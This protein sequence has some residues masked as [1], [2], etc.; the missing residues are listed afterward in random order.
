M[1]TLIVCRSRS[2]GNTGKVARAMARVLGAEVVEPWAIEPHRVA[3]YDLVGFGS[4]IYA[5]SF[6]HELRRFVASI[7]AAQ[8]ASAFVFATAGFGRVI[9]RPFRERLST[10]VEAAGYRLIGSFCC[11][12]FDTW[13]PLRLVGGLNKGRPNEADLE[14]ARKFAQNLSDRSR[15]GNRERSTIMHANVGD[16]IVVDAPHTGDVQR[17]GEIV[18]VLDAGG[19]VHYR[20]RW[21]D[22]HVSLFFP[23]S[24][25]HVSRGS[26]PR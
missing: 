8:D 14:R 21:E 13:L 26:A 4:G 25:A 22:G 18:E 19:T 17:K 20:V 10:L 23:G 11:P 3:E 12:G 24:D 1:S 15:P 9:E 16:E 6:D 7:S 5:L 2:H